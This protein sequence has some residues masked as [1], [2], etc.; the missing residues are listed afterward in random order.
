MKLYTFI[1]FSLLLSGC[2]GSSG[3][4]SDVTDG[5]TEIE[6]PIDP[7]DGTEIEIPVVPGSGEEIELPETALDQCESEGKMSLNSECVEW[8]EVYEVEHG[9]IGEDDHLV[10]VSP[11]EMTFKALEAQHETTNGNGWRHEVKIK[12]SGG[13]RVAMTEVYELFKANIKAELSD[14]SKIIV[15]QHHAETT[16]TITKLYVSDLD[17]SGFDRAPDGRQSDSVAKNGI[18][19][20]YIRLAKADGSGE[21]KH[22]LT[23]IRSG[24]SFDFEEEN[25]H[26]VVT[27]KINGQALDSISV[28]DSS[29]SYFKF[30][31]YHQSQNP[32]NNE[33]I[34]DKDEWPA[35]Y[36][37]YFNES[38]ITFTNMSYIRNVDE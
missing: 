8:S 34:S 30:G 21:T 27:V 12:S 33:K 28:N 3:G 23:T 29:E 32:D 11:I 10:S 20:V 14:G 35:F 25:D 6:V 1:F 2:G 13:Y 36:A 15:A 5:N 7:N 17:E 16:D 19:D 18:F 22:L 4:S 26:G 24:E 38:N 9:I 31:N 37:E